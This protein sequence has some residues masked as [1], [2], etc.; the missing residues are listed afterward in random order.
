[1]MGQE[2][3]VGTSGGKKLSPEVDH[4]P[5][6]IKPVQ[7]NPSFE[8][9]ECRRQLFCLSPVLSPNVIKKT[10]KKEYCAKA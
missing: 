9:S 8:G 6:R 1:M 7:V 2:P 5:L 3:W 10:L 4:S